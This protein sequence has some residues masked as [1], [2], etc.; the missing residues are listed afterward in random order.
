MSLSILV[1]LLLFLVLIPL[2]AALLSAC[3]EM[4][5]PS[6]QA[7]T[8]TSERPRQRLGTLPGF[9]RPIWPLAPSHPREVLGANSNRNG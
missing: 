3:R 9:R 7:L 5:S 2:V 4:K 6:A 1:S 8:R